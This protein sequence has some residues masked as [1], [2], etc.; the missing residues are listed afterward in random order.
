LAGPGRADAYDA[1]PY[2]WCDQYDVKLQMLGVPSGYDNLEVIEGDVDDW[3][4]V[5]AYGKN[6]RIIAVLSTIPGRVHDYRSAIAD[7]APFPSRL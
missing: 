7:R 6:G 1:V 3:K 5:A 4:F 2:F